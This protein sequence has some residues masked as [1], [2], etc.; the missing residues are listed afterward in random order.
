MS[1]KNLNANAVQFGRLD[2]TNPEILRAFV[3]MYFFPLTKLA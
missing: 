1:G 2:R 3:V